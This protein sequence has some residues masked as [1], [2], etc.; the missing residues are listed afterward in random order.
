[1]PLHCVLAKSWHSVRV[2]VLAPVDS[3]QRTQKS[4]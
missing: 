1:M 3:K 4:L 2:P